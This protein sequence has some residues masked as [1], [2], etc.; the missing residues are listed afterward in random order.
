ML[1]SNENMEQSMKDAQLSFVV[2]ALA[3][4]IS[5]GSNTVDYEFCSSN[6]SFELRPLIE[7]CSGLVRLRNLRPEESSQM[8]KFK[9]SSAGSFNTVNRLLFFVE[10]ILQE[11]IRNF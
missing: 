5:Y 4:H 10:S 7:R 2:E 11:S 8:A 6:S 3:A 1:L 9:A